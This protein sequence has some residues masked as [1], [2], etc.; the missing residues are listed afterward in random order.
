MVGFWPTLDPIFSSLRP[1]N[2]PL[3]ISGGRGQSCLHWVK[4]SALDLVGKDP[5]RWF[6]V[7]M[8]HYQICRTRLPEL[9]S[10]G[11]RRR[12]GLSFSLK[13]PYGV[14]DKVQRIVFV[15]D[16]LNLVDVRYIKCSCKVG[17]MSSFIWVKEEDNEHWPDNVSSS[18]YF[19]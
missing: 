7:G 18:P 15:Q 6:K 5:N 16:L 14:V 8:V 19:F 13:K 17:D 3:F 2:P 1:W 11:W 9:A 4:L 12:N 10:L